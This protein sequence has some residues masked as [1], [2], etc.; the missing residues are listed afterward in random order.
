MTRILLVHPQPTRGGF[1]A[2]VSQ[3]KELLSIGDFEVAVMVED[4]PRVA[5]LPPEVE[6]IRVD[7]RLDR[8]SGA[9]QLGREIRRAG[10]DIVHFHGRKAGVIGRTLLPRHRGFRVVYTPHGTPWSG[11]S[12]S[13]LIFT[14]VTER[15]LLRRAD[16]VGC[17]SHSEQADWVRRDLSDRVRYLPNY[18]EVSEVTKLHESDTDGSILAPGGYH[19][20]KRLDVILYAME[21]CGSNVPNLVI[22]GEVADRSY[23]TYIRSLAEKLNIASRVSLEQNLPDLLSRLGGADRVVLSSYSEGMPIVGQQAVLAGANVIWSAIPPH[24]ELFGG[25][26]AS[27]S[28][29]SDLASLLSRPAQD[30]NVA[31][32]QEHLVLHEYANRERRRAFWNEMRRPVA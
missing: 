11:A 18:M 19:P 7:S 4:G 30:F 23:F 21:K 32:R 26:G 12:L 22:C 5:E 29:A 20:Q 24:F 9:L 27:F 17:V 8:P 25:Y 15:A 16:I 10:Y 28:T 13:R 2:V 6:V 31:G 1:S 3:T 14:E